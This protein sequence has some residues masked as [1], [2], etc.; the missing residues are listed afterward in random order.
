MFEQK[1]NKLITIELGMWIWAS[2][3]PIWYEPPLLK[4]V[5]G[6]GVPRWRRVAC[7][8]VISKFGLAPFG[9]KQ[10]GPCF[11]WASKSTR[12]HDSNNAALL[13]TTKF[14]LLWAFEKEWK[15][16][17][18]VNLFTTCLWRRRWMGNSPEVG[19]LA[20]EPRDFLLGFVEP[21]FAWFDLT[22]WSDSNNVAWFLMGDL[23]RLSPW[24]GGLGR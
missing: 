8:P 17:S 16:E 19:S 6:L 2:R 1:R 11:S 23:L 24:S 9:F 10:S 18:T 14:W 15:K 21:S 5:V 22:T 3:Y 7:E 13:S 12:L 4:D 20:V